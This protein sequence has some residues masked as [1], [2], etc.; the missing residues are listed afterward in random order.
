MEIDFANMQATE[1]FWKSFGF[2]NEKKY[3]EFI[4]ENGLEN[5]SGVE[6]IRFVMDKACGACRG[7]DDKIDDKN[8]RGKKVNKKKKGE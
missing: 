8:G 6:V 3:Q 5:K 4:K 7:C 2:E 1:S